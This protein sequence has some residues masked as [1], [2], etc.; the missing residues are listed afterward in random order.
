MFVLTE[1]INKRIERLLAVES[2]RNRFRRSL[3][4]KIGNEKSAFNI[5]RRTPNSKLSNFRRDDF[6]S[7]FAETVE[8]VLHSLRFPI[9]TLVADPAITNALSCLFIRQ[10]RNVRRINMRKGVGIVAGFDIDDLN[11][12]MTRNL[13]AVLHV[14]RKFRT[15]GKIK[16]FSLGW[17]KNDPLILGTIFFQPQFQSSAALIDNRGLV[18]R[19]DFDF[20]G[21]AD[22][23]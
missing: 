12:Q 2:S 21:T 3:Q 22:I 13:A 18:E 19:T 17:S 9:N 6:E 4:A 5:Q 15:F 23:E 8:I 16:I 1:L 10:Q 14:K 11:S 20:A 7:A